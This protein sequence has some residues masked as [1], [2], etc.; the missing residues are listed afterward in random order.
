MTPR[1]QFGIG[2]RTQVRRWS[3]DTVRRW[4]SA[5]KRYLGYSPAL[6]LGHSPALELGCKKTPQMQFGVGARTQEDTAARETLQ[7]RGVA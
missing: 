1:I 3:S 5:A 4:G 2:A 6:E 7:T